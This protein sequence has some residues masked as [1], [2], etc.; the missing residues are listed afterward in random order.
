MDFK[1]SGF[2]YKLVILLVKVYFANDLTNC[3]QRQVDNTLD[4]KKTTKGTFTTGHL[5]SKS[6]KA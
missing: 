2:W 6:S 1:S 4:I 3:L 5:L